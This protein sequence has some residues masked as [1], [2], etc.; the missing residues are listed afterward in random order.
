[1]VELIKADGI[2][3][4]TCAAKTLTQEGSV[5]QPWKLGPSNKRKHGFVYGRNHKSGTTLRPKLCPH[6]ENK[7]STAPSTQSLLTK[8]FK[9]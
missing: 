3:C 8:L 1:V 5:C 9:K 2:A 4:T 7:V 6:P